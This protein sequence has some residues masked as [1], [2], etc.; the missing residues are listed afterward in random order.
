[1]TRF[2]VSERATQ[3]LINITIEG[4]QR[5]GVMQS[6]K[7]QAELDEKFAMLSEF[8]KMGRRAD[9]IRNGLRRHEHGSHVIFYVEES[10]GIVIVAVV[11][12]RS[13]RGLD[14]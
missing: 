1:V 11:H 5:F 9:S 10:E 3:D 6:D 12:A 13:L 7:Y 14:L 2:T 8:R 4:Y